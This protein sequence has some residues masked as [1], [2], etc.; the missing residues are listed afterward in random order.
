MISKTMSS[1]KIP[2]ANEAQWRLAHRQ[3]L[4]IY[5]TR[6]SI[7]KLQSWK[8]GI[9]PPLARHH[10]IE[11]LSKYNLN[12]GV[13]PRKTLVSLRDQPILL[14]AS[15]GTP[16]DSLLPRPYDWSHAEDATLSWLRPRDC[17]KLPEQR[18]KHLSFRHFQISSK[19]TTTTEIIIN[20]D[21]K[22]F[23][24]ASTQLVPV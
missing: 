5:R 19:E 24:F 16:E 17:Q 15:P 4:K 3:H 18:Q 11:L 21:C 23:Y 1:N 12:Q 22:L 20:L 13:A 14:L 7:W 8:I 2:K 10:S 9:P 6:K